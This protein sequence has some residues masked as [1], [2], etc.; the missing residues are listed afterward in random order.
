MNEQLLKTLSLQEKSQ[1]N[2]MGIGPVPFVRP[3]VY[4]CFINPCPCFTNPVQSIFYHMPLKF[5]LV[6]QLV[7]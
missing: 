3:R 1:K 6:N 2:L 5:Q 7:E 4:P